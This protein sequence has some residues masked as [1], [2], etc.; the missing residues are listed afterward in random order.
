MN[1]NTIR[2]MIFT[3]L[4]TALYVVGTLVR[5]PFPVVPLVLTNMFLVLGGFILGPL[6]GAVSVLLYLFI[7]F[8]GLPVFS[9]GG[10]IALLFGPTGGYLVGYI[11]CAFLAG[12]FR[13]LTHGKAYGVIIGS[14]IGMLSVYLVGVPWLKGVLAADWMKSLTLG[15]FPFIIGDLVKCSLAVFIVL[16]IGNYAPKYLLNT[17]WSGADKKDVSVQEND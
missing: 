4:F 14:V 2:N 17:S 6:W 12:A 9:G 5:I 8:L 16:Y 13:N 1:T 7:G 11:L 15:L 3:S 10:G